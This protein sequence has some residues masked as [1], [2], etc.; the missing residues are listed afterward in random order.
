MIFSSTGDNR[1]RAI[2]GTGIRL[3]GSK[4]DFYGN[5]SL[6]C[7]NQNLISL[8]VED[9]DFDVHCQGN[10]LKELILPASVKDVRCDKELLDYDTCTLR[11][12][13]IFYE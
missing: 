3:D 2:T 5:V 11:T 6:Y 9:G 12:L 8:Y 7:P 1:Y 10:N 13:D 4:Q